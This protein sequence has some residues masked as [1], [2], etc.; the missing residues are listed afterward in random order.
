[1]HHAPGLATRG[2]Q[3]RVSAA[4]GRIDEAEQRAS[5]FAMVGAMMREDLEESLFRFVERVADEPRWRSRVQ[6]AMRVALRVAIV[7]SRVLGRDRVLDELSALAARW[8][9]FRGPRLARMLDVEGRCVA[10][11]H[12]TACPFADLAAQDTRICTRLVHGLESATFQ[13]IVPEYRLVPLGRLLSK[14]DASC[15]FRHE[16]PATESASQSLPA[17][18]LAKETDASRV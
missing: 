4:R 17:T 5:R 3:G 14:G 13:S 1:V 7:E 2:G 6:R 12:E 10:T 11:K 18:D 15:T 9:R 8:G 16:I